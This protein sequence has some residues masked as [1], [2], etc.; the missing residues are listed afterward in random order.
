MEDLRYAH[1][2]WT[3]TNLPLRIYFCNCLNIDLKYFIFVYIF[4]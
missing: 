4:V 2:F 3:I 1:I